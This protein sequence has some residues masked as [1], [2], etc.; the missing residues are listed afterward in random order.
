VS[1]LEQELKI[2]VASTDALRQR[3]TERG[4]LVSR[5][6]A[7]EDNWVLDDRTG[8]LAT[9][10]HLLRLRRSGGRALLTFKG[11]ATFAGGVKSR[12]EFET[13]VEDADAALA[14]L[15][16]L[17]FAPVRRYQKRREVWTVEGVAV[18]LDETPMGSFVEL[19]GEAARL[20]AVAAKLGLD[21]GA[22]A[23]GTYLD[24]W[25]AYRAAHPEAPEDM[26]FPPW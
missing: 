20:T 15:A 23:R 16:A 12:A 17:G 19:E 3:L 25:V 24:L 11:T 10:G 2:A 26:L 14:I 21:P 4:G 18:M 7:M 6:R 8:T 1:V 5:A 9:A 22:A 13:A